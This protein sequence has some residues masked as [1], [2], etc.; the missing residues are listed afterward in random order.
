MPLSSL[1]PPGIAGYEAGRQANQQADEAQL[2]GLAKLLQLS[3]TMQ[4]APLQRQLLE[5]QIKDAQQKPQDR[6]DAREQTKQ[7]AMARLAETTSRNMAQIAHNART[8]GTAEERLHWTQ[9]IDV[10]KA[11]ERRQAADIAAGRFTYDTGGT[12]APFQGAI[13]TPGTPAPQAAPGLSAL[14]AGRPPEEQAALTKVWGNGPT[15]SAQPA[16]VDVGAYDPALKVDQTPALAAPAAPRSVAEQFAPETRASAYGAEG[17]FP[18]VGATAATVGLPA[19]SVVAPSVATMPPAIAAL[20]KKLQDKWIAEQAGVDVASPNAQKS[21]EFWSEVLQKGGSLPPGLA[22]TKEGAALVKEVMKKV[23]QGETKPVELLASQAEFMGEKAG[24]R[25]LGTRT[26]NIEIASQEA[27]G[28]SK[29]ALQASEE[30]NRTGIKT[31]NDLEKFAQGRT[32]SPELRRFV[33]ANTSFIN[34]YARAIN[35][36]GV[37]TVADKEHAREMLEVGFS[38]GDYAAAINQLQA[39]IATAQASPGQVKA[40][41]RERFTGSAPA[42]SVQEFATEADAAKAGLKPGT[43]IKIN[44]RPGTWQ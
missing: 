31:L 34:A 5:A 27:A 10:L 9:Q 24:Q 39:E 14:L 44:G 28:L 41:M 6:I 2:G 30:W 8:A 25:T 15:P 11:N 13:P 29:L 12:I 23:S 43:K 42:A 17:R 36:Q 38:K 40:S 37:G 19:A 3:Q 35:P 32:A 21:V 33:A 7:I 4:N 20:P 1:L 18:P 26:A 22:R 16:G